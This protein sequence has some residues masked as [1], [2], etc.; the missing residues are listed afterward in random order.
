VKTSYT[1]LDLLRSFA[2]LSVVAAHL[3]H[4]SAAFHLCAYNSVIDQVL[5]N[6]SFTGVMFFFVHTCLVLMLSMHRAPAAHRGRNFLI[7]RA[8]RIY[9]LCWA[10]ILVALSTGLSD[11]P[12]ERLHALGWGGMMVNAALLQNMLR[13]HASVIG[14]LWSLPWEVQMYLLLPLF[15]VLL[16]R[17]DQLFVVFSLWLGATTLALVATQPA[18]PRL[19]HAAVF[20]PMFIAGMVAYKLLVRRPEGQRRFLFP[21]WLW[22]F[23]ILG[24]FALQGWLVR[25][26]SFESPYGSV[27]N[28]CIC[29]ALAVSIP[30]FDELCA[31]WVVVP[32][33]QAAKYSYGIYLLHV[34]ALVFVLRYLPGLPLTLKLAAFVGLTALLAFVSFHAIEDPLIRLGKRLTQVSPIQSQP[35][36]PGQIPF[37]AALPALHGPNGGA[38]LRGESGV[39]GQ[40]SNHL[41]SPGENWMKLPILA[42]QDIDARKLATDESPLMRR[43]EACSSYPGRVGENIQSGAKQEGDTIRKRRLLVLTPRFPY[44]EIAGD[45]IR[46]LHICRALSA[47][48]ELTLLSLCETREE[49][50]FQPQDGLFPTIER[51]YLPR[52]RSYLNTALAIPGSRP[53]QLA[54]YESAEFRAKV[55]SLLPQHDLALAHLI[56]T[57]QYLEDEPG[58][59]I[60]EMTDAVS[61]NYLRMR[62]LSGSYNWKRL[63]Y[64]LEQG[65]LKTYE[66]R[67]QQK[68]DRVLLT[69]QADRSF[70]DPS[71]I[72][73]I[74]V[75][76]NG[77]DLEK[78]PFRTPAL[79]A[80]VIVFIGNMVSLQNQ[81]ACH[82]FIQ[83]ILPRVQARANVV[84]RI[85]GSAP[86]AVQRR[87]SRYRGVRVTGRIE[88]IQEGVQGA[89]CGV[90][91][92]RAGAGIQNKVLEYLALGLP[93]VTS[94]VGLSGVSALPG[95]ELLVYNDPDEAAQK[96]LMLY[97]DPAL[98]LKMAL[99]GRGLVSR[100]YDWQSIYRE[101]NDSCLTVLGEARKRPMPEHIDFQTVAADNHRSSLRGATAV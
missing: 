70:L 45:R 2:V 92:V 61:M 33:K 35:A 53:L 39:L 87:F 26:N 79:D 44:P 77:A 40:I 69:S 10:T 57:G 6:L 63:V 13:S 101:F 60:L 8:F 83:N 9:P 32:A 72:W 90:C 67:A 5:H 48:F 81:D 85:V 98:R 75:I 97:S 19:F 58:P 31:G 1:N 54:Y 62:K 12:G 100:K 46:I 20:P 80:N 38:I 93:C 16:R 25:E 34:P 88:R 15:F 22:P 17:F 73:P 65:R 76:P 30:A 82:Y 4:Q 51:V 36:L 89:F 18:L 11:V 86:E 94:T 71:H 43:S 78:L 3:Y 37:V 50:Q 95:M 23:F 14:P 56:R 7:R 28:A 55:K 59:R 84:F 99:A 96:I 91:P 29:L 49:M 41:S 66:L 47:H 64:L 42:G 21:S 74:D 27:V 24:L 68:F 52:W